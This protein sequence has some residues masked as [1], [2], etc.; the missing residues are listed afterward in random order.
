MKSIT[1]KLFAVTLTR[2]L[3]VVQ[4]E[5]CECS[6]LSKVSWD[7]TCKTKWVGGGLVYELK[8]NDASHTHLPSGCRSTG[9][10]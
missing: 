3:V 2:Q 4:L 9:G 10:L 6:K 7:A 1:M 5:V 8:S